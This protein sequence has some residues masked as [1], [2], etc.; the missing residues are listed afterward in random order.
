MF[1][2]GSPAL[3]YVFAMLEIMNELDLGRKTYKT[4]G[5]IRTPSNFMKLYRELQ[6]LNVNAMNIYAPVVLPTVQWLF[7]LWVV[8]C[9]YGFLKL[10]GLF[11]FTTC[12]CVVG[13]LLFLVV[14]FTILAEME[15]RSRT[16]LTNWAGQGQ[17]KILE[18]YLRSCKSIRVT[19][20]TFYYADHGM[21]LTM[22]S[23][24]TESTVNLLVLKICESCH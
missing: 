1:L 16:V 20:G 18:K 21:V 11:A 24:I 10:S 8:F 14:L 23:F 2:Y 4:S 3:D 13:L 17:S 22:L 5:R 12:V 9:S 15:V 6:I 7:S 19:M